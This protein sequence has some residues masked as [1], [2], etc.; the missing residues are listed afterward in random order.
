MKKIATGAVIV[1]VAGAVA[2]GIRAGQERAPEPAAAA[3]SVTAAP[4]GTPVPAG[5][6]GTAATA[7]GAA[8][9]GSVVEP[10]VNVPPASGAP[11]DR[12]AVSAPA[13]EEVTGAGAGAPAGGGAGG[14]PPASGEAQEDVESILQRTA[15]AYEGVRS[16]Q[17]EFVQ[18]LE[19][20]LLGTTAT[21]R[22]TLY[23]RRPDRFLMRF[24]EPA[25][26]VI[27]SDGRYFWVYYPSVNARQ[28]VRAPASQAA[29]GGVDLQAQF[30]GDPV[31]RFVAKL[32]GRESV[33]GR[34]AHVVHLVPREPSG[35][36]ALRVWIDVR[37]GLVR[38]FE[39][40][41]RNETVRRFDLR[42]L[43]VNPALGDE[44]FRFVPP[45]DAQIVEGG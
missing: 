23:Q 20:P 32:E 24:T 22:G 11:D 9:A 37:D 26:D 28:V 31:Q 8:A 42:G 12:A 45:A 4:A 40:H 13:A 2:L 33:D 15:A 34:P 29:T 38:R 43:R 21:S 17:A 16:M 10:E 14:A 44:L 18:R 35:Y 30:I 5:A 1:G 41:E 25:G 39:I 6:A 36:R 19:N 3:P 7:P 27:V